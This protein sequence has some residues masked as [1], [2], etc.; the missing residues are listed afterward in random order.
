MGDPTCLDRLPS[1]AAALADL[2]DIRWARGRRHAGIP[3]S[4]MRLMLLTRAPSAL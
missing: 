1:L 3:V 4:P 2:P